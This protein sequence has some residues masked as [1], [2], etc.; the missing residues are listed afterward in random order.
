[1][2]KKPIK[3]TD[4]NGAEREE[5]H[6]FHLSK[7]DLMD[8]EMENGGSLQ[9]VIT[10]MTEITDG[11][12]IYKLIKSIIHK[13]YGVKDDN[14]GFDKDEKHLKKFMRTDAYSE[15]I[16]ELIG[17]PEE[18]AAFFKGIMPKDIQDEIAK[19]EKLLA[20]QAK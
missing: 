3:Y 19:N 20:D 10:R 5:T 14:G 16:I 2:L 1:M 15:L 13:A 8:L 12:T 11:P 17:N 18:A 6:Y 9:S 7:A 4:Y